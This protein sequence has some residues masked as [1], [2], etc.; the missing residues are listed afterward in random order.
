[1]GTP[2]IINQRSYSMLNRSIEAD[3]LKDYAA[4]NGIGIITFCP[5]AQGS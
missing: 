1:M 4:K 5:L 2:F 3:G